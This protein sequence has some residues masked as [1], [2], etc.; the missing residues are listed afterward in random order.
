MCLY[1]IKWPQIFTIL[2]WEY[3]TFVAL[4][5]SKICR[6]RHNTKKSSPEQEL[7]WILRTRWHQ[8]ENTGWRSGFSLRDPTSAMD[9]T[10]REIP[11][12]ARASA[13]YAAFSHVDKIET[14]FAENGRSFSIAAVLL[15]FMSYL[16]KRKKCIFK[17]VIVNCLLFILD[18]VSN[19]FFES[20]TTIKIAQS[21]NFAWK[22]IIIY[23][24]R[25]PR[26]RRLFWTM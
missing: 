2:V 17:I 10:E 6:W 13:N 26:C 23:N 11:C 1:I 14:S 20:I 24:H 4:C 18:Y 16:R 9:R 22:D 7:L 12:Y 15:A 25:C 21:N 8:W 5:Y 3:C 19:R